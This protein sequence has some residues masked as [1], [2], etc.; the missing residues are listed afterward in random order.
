MEIVDMS[1]R[2]IVK[3]L[4]LDGSFLLTVNLDVVWELLEFQG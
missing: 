2:G 3:E 4:L 1:M